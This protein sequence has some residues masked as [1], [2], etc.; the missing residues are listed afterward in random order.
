MKTLYVYP[1]SSWIVTK[2]SLEGIPD[3]H[4]LI[5]ERAFTNLRS[6]MES[7]SRTGRYVTM[8]QVVNLNGKTTK[9]IGRTKRLTLV[10]KIRHSLGI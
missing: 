4:L 10:Q 1:E 5:I 7:S 6:A 2:E 3:E 9:L 8:T